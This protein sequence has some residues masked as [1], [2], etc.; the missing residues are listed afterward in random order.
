[1]RALRRGPPKALTQAALDRFDEDGVLLPLRGI[2]TDEA[3][4][5][6][7]L[8]EAHERDADESG[9]SLF[10]N[11]HLMYDWQHGLATHPRIL[12]MVEDV[13]GPDIFVWKCQLWIKE[14]GS[15]AHVGWHQDAAYWGLE[16]PDAVNVWMALSDVTAAHGPM[17]LLR[18]SHAE[19]LMAHEDRYEPSNLLTRGQVIP[20]LQD[21]TPGPDPARTMSAVLAPGE[22]SLHHL[23]TAHG[24]GPNRA[25]DR[26]IGF[27]VTYVP[28]TVRSVRPAGASAMLVRGHDAFGHFAHETAPG[29]EAVDVHARR[30]AHAAKVEGVAASIMDGADMGRFEQVSQQRVGRNTPHHVSA[31]SAGSTSLASSLL[32]RSN[33][34]EEGR[35]RE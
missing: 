4:H 5:A 14:A 11:G 8:I 26:R 6:R 3:L 2:D 24:G 23:C 1:M 27:N 28:P 34:Q 22:L 12:D 33:H 13:I 35:E 18:G 29:A 31:A 19:P 9:A 10:T 20:A 16:P 15:D 25:D 17:E 30:R 7:G 21:G 32:R